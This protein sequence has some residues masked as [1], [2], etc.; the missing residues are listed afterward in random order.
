MSAQASALATCMLALVAAVN[1]T[2]ATAPTALDGYLADL[3]TLRAEFTQTVTDAHGKSV[4]SGSG[5]L[6]V[7]RPGKFRWQY[8]PRGG[9]PDAGQELVADGRSLWFYERDLAQVTVKPMDEALSATPMMLLS[10]TPAQ[11]AAA[12]SVTAGARRDALEWAVVTP[13]DA[14]ADFSRAELAFRGATLQ[15]MVISDK[16][17]QTVT[18]RFT[19]SVRNGAVS[20]AELTFSPPADADVIG[21]V[22]R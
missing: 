17:G 7:Q 20:A 21:T 5:I 9:G 4:E 19:R 14:G 10:G 13:R 18:L 6:L 3:R 11:L 1:A 12:F 15:R 22:P 16:L 8:A 2:A